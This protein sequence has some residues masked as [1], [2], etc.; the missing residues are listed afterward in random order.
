[1]KTTLYLSAF[2]ALLTFP[3]CS[4]NNDRVSSNLSDQYFPN[5]VGNQWVYMV[6]DSL[7]N[8][9]DTVIVTI[10]GT[11]SDPSSGETYKVWQ[12]K[13]PD[14]MD[15]AYVETKG[16][17][18]R[19]LAD[20]KKYDFCACLPEIKSEID[21][22]GLA[23]MNLYVFPLYMNQSIPQKG[24]GSFA[25]WT[26]SNVTTFTYQNVLGDEVSDT[27]FEIIKGSFVPN[28]TINIHEFF[29][30]HVGMIKLTIKTGAWATGKIYE[31]W[32]LLNSNFSVRVIEGT[33]K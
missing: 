31:Y 15:T 10:T 4:K 13:W 7:K 18:V 16:D 33:T 20:A 5:K 8:V 12:Y 19:F 25:S 21:S 23:T 28:S 11:I 32:E 6:T 2:M 3:S 24:Y 26:N 17:T 9:T 29:V 1:M 30:P 22:N 27:S 14:R